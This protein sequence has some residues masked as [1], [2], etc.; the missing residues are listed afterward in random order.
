MK[1]SQTGRILTDEEIEELYQ[2]WI[3]GQKQTHSKARIAWDVFMF[4]GCTATAAI[5]C[6]AFW[7]GVAWVLIKLWRAL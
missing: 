7:W 2:E 6:V 1:D 3:N 5:F 4:A